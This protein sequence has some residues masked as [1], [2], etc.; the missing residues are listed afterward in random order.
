S[1]LCGPAFSMDNNLYYWCACQIANITLKYGITDASAHGLVLFGRVLGPLLRCYHDGY[2]LGRIGV[3][4]VEKH[5]FIAYKAK[6]YFGAA[7]SA[8]WT[9]PVTVAVELLRVASRA[10]AE[11]GDVLHQCY[12][13]DHLIAYLFLRG[14]RLEEME[15]E[16]EK[17]M[18][19]LRSSRFSDG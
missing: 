10:A 1:A 3:D 19:F 8:I 11:T 18:H 4:L 12:C 16:A 7:L 5:G 6:V 2:L 9:E 14:D 17:A 13:H 15:H